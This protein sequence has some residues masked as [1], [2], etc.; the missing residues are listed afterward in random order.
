VSALQLQ[1]VW[2]AYAKAPAVAG[3]T[4]RVD[5]GEVVAL[6]G[7]NGAGK[8]TLTR[9]IMGLLHPSQ[10]DILVMGVPNME[11][12]PEQIARDAAY[13]FQHADQQLFSRTVIEEVAFAPLQLG[14]SKIDARDIAFHALLD[15][16]L[17]AQAAVHPYDLSPAERKL[18]ALAAALA[19]QPRLLILDEPT[20]GLD[21]S[22][23][24]R[25]CETL[26]QLAG[27]KVAILFVSHDLGV[28]AEIADRTVVMENGKIVADLPA[29]ALV[30]DA[31][32]IRALG[33]PLPPAAGLSLALKL[34]GTPVRK[35]QVVQALKL[36]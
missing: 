10:G 14:R 1:D 11:Q 4:L 17:E 7:P 6:L 29:P 33:M 5:P 21:A 28:V 15:L 35:S 2:F 32:R 13:V 24:D 12:L 25:V 20:Q 3:V 27:E 18:V 9:L 30:A 34:P 8:S 26:R 31:D 19:Q 23:R 16:G 36:R 22:L